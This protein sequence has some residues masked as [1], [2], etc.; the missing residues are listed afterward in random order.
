MERSTA[1]VVVPIHQFLRGHAEGHRCKERIGGMLT[2][3]IVIGPV[4]HICLPG[5]YGVEHLERAHQFTGTL[6]VDHD[7]AIGHAV[8]VVGGALCG[9]KHARKAPTPCRDHGQIA[10]A[11]RIERC[12]QRRRGNSSPATQ[13][14]VFQKRATI[15]VVS[16]PLL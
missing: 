10:H 2:D 12:R 5:G 11:L 1:V 6:D 16:S 9:V 15:H 8:D 4:I 7:A 13:S 3:E 14:G